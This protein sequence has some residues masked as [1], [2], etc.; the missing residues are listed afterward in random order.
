M[1][2][3]Y[4]RE[5]DWAV[6]GHGGESRWLGVGGWSYERKGG[7]G[8]CTVSRSVATLISESFTN[9]ISP[10]YNNIY[11]ATLCNGSLYKPHPQ[12]TR[13]YISFQLHMPSTLA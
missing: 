7:I 4:A 8:M 1:K 10:A 13:L 6:S 5:I 9:S 2:G 11:S 12:S 3:G